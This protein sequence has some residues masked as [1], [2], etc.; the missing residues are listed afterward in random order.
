[1]AELSNVVVVYPA[2]ISDTMLA[3]PVSAVLKQEAPA[4]KITAIAEPRLCEL[5]L[6]VCPSIDEAVEL[7]ARAGRS[8]LMALVKELSPELLINLSQ[9]TRK[10]SPIRSA[11]SLFKSA[12]P[13]VELTPTHGKNES[14]H[15]VNF[16]LTAF[17]SLGCSLPTNPFP[18]IFPEALIE[19]QLLPLLQLYGL[20]MD[21]PIVGLVP[22]VGAKMTS[23]A[24]F[25]DGWLYL[26]R[27]LKQYFDVKVLLLG[28]QADVEL[29]RAI[30]AES[31]EQCIDLS[32][33]LTLVQAAT[34]IKALALLISSY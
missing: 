13:Y 16:Y 22:G 30:A 27:A 34:L 5:L 26:I 9:I 8:E 29:C 3:T 17:A 14:I 32:G 24:W 20:S 4:A 11:I 19:S 6:S 21:E 12:S 2:G 28:G 31:S 23:K 15:Q 18:T 1:M 25:N 10:E 33:K 7:D